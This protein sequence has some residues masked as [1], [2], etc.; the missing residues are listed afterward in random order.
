MKKLESVKNKQKEI[1]D[2]EH[3]LDSLL[4]LVKLS[5][6]IRTIADSSII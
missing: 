6:T 2:R 1:V 5:D 4:N 3:K